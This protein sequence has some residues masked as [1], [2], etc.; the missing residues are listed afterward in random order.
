[1]SVGCTVLV[2]RKNGIP[3]GIIGQWLAPVANWDLK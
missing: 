1:L 2:C 3:S